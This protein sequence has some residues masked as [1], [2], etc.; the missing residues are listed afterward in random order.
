M[1]WAAFAQIPV[2]ARRALV[3]GDMLELGAA[4]SAEHRR[5]GQAA[6]QAAPALLLAVGTHAAE[7]ADG[8]RAEG[9]PP[10]SIQTAPDAGAAAALLR[11]W[12]RAGDALLLK[13]SRGVRLERVLERL[14]A[15][16]EA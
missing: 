7:V 3:L 6:A 12:L 16:G 13:G 9:F 1:H 14:S 8:A 10:S 2:A 11:G 15:A 4:A 5:L